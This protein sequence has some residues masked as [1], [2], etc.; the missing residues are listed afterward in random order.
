[1]K[2]NTRIKY[3]IYGLAGLSVILG[4]AIIYTMLTG[5]DTQP[6]PMQDGLSGAGFTEFKVDRPCYKFSVTEC[7]VWSAPKGMRAARAEAGLY[8]TTYKKDGQVYWT[9]RPVHVQAGELVWTDGKR[10]VRA[11]C[12]N[13]IRKQRPAA[14][15]GV[16][17]LEITEDTLDGVIGGPADLTQ[18]TTSTG[19]TPDAGGPVQPGTTSQGWPGVPTGGGGCCGFTGGGPT[20]GRPVQMSEPDSWEMVGIG[21][22]VLIAGMKARR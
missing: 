10:T 17:I 19:G 3:A 16:R 15:T 7:G 9:A 1:M 22:L 4:L 8:Y 11:R 18:Y 6:A 20:P 21:T 2:N 5:R 14:P 12:G 13:E